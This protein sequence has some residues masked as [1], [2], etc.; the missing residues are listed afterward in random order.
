M[1][2]ELDKII[3]TLALYQCYG[4]LCHDCNRECESN[5]QDCCMEDC[6]NRIYDVVI[7]ARDGNIQ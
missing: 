1:D 3:S 2:K 6:K 7:G 5:G 4:N